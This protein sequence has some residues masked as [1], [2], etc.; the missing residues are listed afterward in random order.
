MRYS[1]KDNIV[2]KDGVYYMVVDGKKVPIDIDAP[3]KF[4][5]DIIDRITKEAKWIK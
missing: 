3:P 2:L 4:R 5:A 1:K